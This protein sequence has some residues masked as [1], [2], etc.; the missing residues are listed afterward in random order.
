VDFWNQ[1]HALCPADE[2]PETA[3]LRRRVLELPVHQ[4]LEPEDMTHVARA[5]EEAL[6]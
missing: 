1:G 3:S 5:V 2:F 6:A 4:D